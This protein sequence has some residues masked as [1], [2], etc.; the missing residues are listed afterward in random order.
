[1]TFRTNKWCTNQAALLEM[2]HGL[3]VA[4]TTLAESGMIR[5]EFKDIQTREVQHADVGGTEEDAFRAAIKTFVARKSKAEQLES[6]NADLRQRLADLE[7]E[8]ATKSTTNNATSHG[9]RKKDSQKDDA[10]S[11]GTF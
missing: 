9:S 3:R 11:S 10:V 1:M 8:L 4:F 6:D 2:Q 5:A 7:S